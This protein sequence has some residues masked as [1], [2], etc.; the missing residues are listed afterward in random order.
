MAKRQRKNRHRAKD[1]KELFQTNNLELVTAA[2]I[3]SGLLRVNS[4]Q[5]TRKGTL[6]VILFGEF[7]ED[8]SSIVENNT[9]NLSHL[10]SL[11]QDDD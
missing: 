6:S 4:I 11:L 5:L 8:L 10:Y 2:L 3:L 1:V 7:K 9:D